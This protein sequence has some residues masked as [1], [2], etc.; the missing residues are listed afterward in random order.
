MPV[1]LSYQKCEILTEPYTQN[2]RTYVNIKT[3][4]GANKQV[5]WYSDWEWNKLHPELAIK[6]N[7]KHSLGF[8]EGYITIYYGETYPNLDWFKAKDEC[9]YNKKWG[10]YTAS[11][12]TV[13]IDIPAGVSTAQLTWETA[14]KDGETVDEMAVEAFMNHLK[15]GDSTSQ[16]VGEIGDRLDLRL[17]I[18]KVIP[19]EG[20]YGTSSLHIMHD[21]DG[22]VYVWSASTK[23]LEAGI[24][25]HMRG[26][27]KDHRQYRGVNQTVLTRC[28]VIK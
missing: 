27:V 15:Y 5:R 19:V 8:D 11:T 20:Y 18:D 1:A 22:N 26:T 4:A 28:S 17:T 2:G 24:E 12:E 9:R 16:Y 10:W 21:V 3:A 23:T 14:S 6:P 25:Y 13:P 7:Y